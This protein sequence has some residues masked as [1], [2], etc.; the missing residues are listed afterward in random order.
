MMKSGK[1]LRRRKLKQEPSYH[2]LLFFLELGFWY[3]FS[4]SSVFDRMVDAL[5]TARQIAQRARR[6][7]ERLEREQRAASNAPFDGSSSDGSSSDGSFLGAEQA[8]AM[9]HVHDMYT[10]VNE[11]DMWLDIFRDEHGRVYTDTIDNLYDMKHELIDAHVVL[12]TFEEQREH[13]FRFGVGLA[14]VHMRDNF[15]FSLNGLMNTIVD[16]DLFAQ[17]MY[18]VIDEEVEI[19]NV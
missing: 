17:M 2:A 16:E 4:R 18:A 12:M 19:T 5:P 7:R 10:F 1:H 3:F 11:N 15:G 9:L 8:M 13:V 14:L 6:E